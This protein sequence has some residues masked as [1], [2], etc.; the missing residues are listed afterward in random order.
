MI[1]FMA[2][3]DS[4]NL[5][6]LVGGSSAARLCLMAWRLP[7]IF[8]STSSASCNNSAARA[9]CLDLCERLGLQGGEARGTRSLLVACGGGRNYHN[10]ESLHLLHHSRTESSEP[11]YKFPQGKLFYC[12]MLRSWEQG[13]TQ[14]CACLHDWER[15]RAQEEA[16]PCLLGS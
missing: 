14:L 7:S 11:V 5:S 13:R 1:S 16:W 4:A 9:I 3:V 8:F 6:F 12:T 10:W 2:S 15:L